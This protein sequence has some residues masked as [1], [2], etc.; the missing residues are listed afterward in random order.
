MRARPRGASRGADALSRGVDGEIPRRRP[1]REAVP[2]RVGSDDGG[3][4]GPADGLR[5]DPPRTGREAVEGAE[6]RDEFGDVRAGPPGAVGLGRPDRLRDRGMLAAAG[7]SGEQPMIKTMMALVVM[8][9]ALYAQDPPPRRP[10]ANPPDEPEGRGRV[11]IEEL[12]KK[13]SDLKDQIEKLPADSEV[14]R[15]E[16]QLAR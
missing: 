15:E 6:D 14:R 11:T 1:A 12:Q 8:G 2:R 16:Q 4:R 7:D 3:G 10:Q 9:S 13:L 5:A